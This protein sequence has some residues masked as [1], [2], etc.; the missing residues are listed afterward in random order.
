MRERERE[1]VKK[2][3][4]IN[5]WQSNIFGQS[6][7]SYLPHKNSSLLL[8][9]LNRK[10]NSITNSNLNSNPNSNLSTQFQIQFQ[11]QFQIRYSHL[12]SLPSI[13]DSRSGQLASEKDKR[14]ISD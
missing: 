12:E 5:R 10:E 4:R 7:S 9:V 11:F 13:S 8:L 14:N 2:F 1:T 3:T 6:L